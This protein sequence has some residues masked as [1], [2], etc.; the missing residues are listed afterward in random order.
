MIGLQEGE[1]TFRSWG[2]AYDGAPG[3]VLGVAQL[4]LVAL[5]LVATCG[6]GHRRRI[7]LLVVAT[8]VLLWVGNFV[9]AA[10]AFDWSFLPA[11]RPAPWMM[12]LPGV[13]ALLHVAWRWDDGVS[14][15]PR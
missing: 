4:V 12:A 14:R 10:V 1:R 3:L 11:A 6:E 8:W 7:G 15:R 13:I 9:Y 2:L 5:A